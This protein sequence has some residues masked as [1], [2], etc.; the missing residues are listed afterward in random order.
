V[1]TLLVACAVV[2]TAL[3]Y[4]LSISALRHLPANV[5]SVL[6]L[7]EPVVA[8]TLAWVIL[9]Q[10]LAVIQLAGAAVLLTGAALVQ[11]ASARRG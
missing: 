3:A 6:A 10:T 8:T 1:W 11:L 2:S 5:A 4:L 9:D 7:V